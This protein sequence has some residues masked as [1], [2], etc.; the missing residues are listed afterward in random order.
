MGLEQPAVHFHNRKGQCCGSRGLK[1]LT[2]AFLGAPLPVDWT[3]LTAVMQTI[4]LG[5]TLNV[6]DYIYI[7]LIIHLG[8]ESLDT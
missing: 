7:A 8:F 5:Y 2:Q 6:L 1:P 4:S 3:P